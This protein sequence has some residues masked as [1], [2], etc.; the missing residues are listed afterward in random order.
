MEPSC[1]VQANPG[2]PGPYAVQTGL[3]FR[4]FWRSVIPPRTALVF[5][6]AAGVLYIRL[7]YQADYFPP[8]HEGEQAQPLLAAQSAF[9]SRRA[10]GSPKE[11]L[12][13]GY[14]SYNK[15]Y[16]LA[17]APVY[18]MFGYDERILTYA[19]PVFFAAYLGAMFILY[20]AA[21]PRASFLAYVPIPVMA[22]LCDCLRRTKWHTIAYIPPLAILVFF[23]P[24]WRPGMAPRARTAARLAGAGGFALACHLYFGSFLYAGPFLVLVALL[25]KRAGWWERG[26]RAALWGVGAFLAFLAAAFAHFCSVNPVW[27][28]RIAGEMG[29]LAGVL[30]GEGVMDRWTSLGDYYWRGMLSPPYLVMY[31]AGLAVLCSRARR[32]DAFAI[33]VLVMY[34]TLWAFQIVLEGVDNPDQLNWSMIPALLVILAGAD[35]L[36]A[37]VRSR[38]PWG[39]TLAFL[40]VL[41]VAWREVYRYPDYTRDYANEFWTQVRDP[42][43][44]AA[45]VLRMVS[46]D[47]SGQ[48]RY[49]MP[50]PSVALPDGGFDYD[51]SLSRPDFA[52]GISR[53]IFF[54]DEAD[55]RRKILLGPRDR[56]AVVYLSTMYATDGIGPNHPETSTGRYLGMDPEL[57][58][59]YWDVYRN[60]FLVRKFKVRPAQLAP[61]SRGGHASGAGVAAR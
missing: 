32:R 4:T 48:V 49:Y 56:W 25:G 9:E 36:V 31:L 22:V 41:V 39:G 14:A 34:G 42:K 35:F 60:E 45:L 23:M 16:F 19:M 28:G 17:L 15:G 61:A 55:L 13:D 7:L 20:R 38:V 6:A 8:Y 37:L 10:T 54:N 1:R 58:S 27:S 11:L 30:T 47:R 5:L 21:Y 59:P 44:E 53:V 57:V 40:L 52:E 3:K 33:V 51:A 46:E 2:N 26:S 24:E 18:G 29:Y 43:S 12:V 50:S